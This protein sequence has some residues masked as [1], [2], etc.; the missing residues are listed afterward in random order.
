MKGAIRT[1]KDLTVWQKAM[2][3]SVEIYRFSSRLPRHE[4]YG[5]TSELRKTSRSIVYNIAEGHKRGSTIDY[6]RF[7]RISAGSAA[8]LESQILLVDRLGYTQKDD[9]E[10]MH[11]RIA[12]IER[13]LDSLIRS[14]TNRLKHS[15]LK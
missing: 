13:M 6:I 2:D 8:E 4:L 7:L 1:F 9:T 15:S 3:M 12:E 11:D 10:L 14:L 5:L